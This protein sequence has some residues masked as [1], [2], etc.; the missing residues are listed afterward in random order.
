[1]C[2]IFA[3]FWDWIFKIWSKLRTKIVLKRIF[4][5]Q[6]SLLDRFGCKPFIL[7]PV[8]GQL[9]SDIGI[10]INYIFIN[11]LPLEFFYIEC[12]YGICGGNPVYFMGKYLRLYVP[13]LDNF[14]EK[15]ISPWAARGSS[16]IK[17][18]VFK[19][20]EHLDE[21]VTFR[22][23]FFHYLPRLFD[24]CTIAISKLKFIAF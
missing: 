9:V 22:W 13:I 16:A 2:S 4:L 24:A 12:V 23:L 17:N 19:M 14:T 1:M 8:F 21:L 20:I 3:V 15:N 18:C 7:L 5:F 10:F 6:G 11:H